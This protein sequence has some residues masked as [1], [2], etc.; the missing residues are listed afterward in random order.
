MLKNSLF[1]VN[2]CFWLKCFRQKTVPGRLRW[3]SGGIISGL[4]G[5]K[6]IYCLYGKIVSEPQTLRS[7][8]PNMKFTSGPEVPSK[9]VLIC[10]IDFLSDQHS[11][12]FR[13]Q[14]IANLVVR[15]RKYWIR[16]WK[17]WFSKRFL[18]LN[19]RSYFLSDVSDSI[20]CLAVCI[21]ALSLEISSV[22]VSFFGRFETVKVFSVF[23]WW[24]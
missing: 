20:C 22:A 16:G 4:K 7:S 5:I 14:P 1:S 15:V 11:V 23:C 24:V 3:R 9:C 13:L 21:S 8:N 10:L 18:P 6:G 2:N 19:F 12:N 17:G